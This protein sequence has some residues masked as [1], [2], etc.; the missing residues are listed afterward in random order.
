MGI[1]ERDR[2]I[3]Y[4]AKGGLVETVTETTTQT[5][6]TDL[7]D[8]GVKETVT[9]ERE[10]VPQMGHHCTC[11]ECQEWEED[12]ADALATLRER[13]SALENGGSN[14]PSSASA[15]DKPTS[16]ADSAPASSTPDAP[17]GE[18]V[19]KPTSDIKD[20]KPTKKHAGWVI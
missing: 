1:D 18:T 17:S 14:S 6:E 5:T 11:E 15:S 3:S 2:H 20:S 8:D 10:Y 7:T 12:I 16:N 4:L 9:V 19:V 13:L